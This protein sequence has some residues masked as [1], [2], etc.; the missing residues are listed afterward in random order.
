M[1]ESTD[2]STT[3]F[4][5]LTSLVSLNQA[6]KTLSHSD[7]IYYIMYFPDDGDKLA[8]NFNCKDV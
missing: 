1:S 3:N 2:P 4:I 5:M 6:D 8:E 7:K